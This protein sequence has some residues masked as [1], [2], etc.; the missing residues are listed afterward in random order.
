ML[1]Y[2]SSSLKDDPRLNAQQPFEQQNS[3]MASSDLPSYG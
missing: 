3:Y 2:G 1:Q